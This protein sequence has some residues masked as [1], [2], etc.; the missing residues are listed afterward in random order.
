[1]QWRSVVAR[2]CP[3]AWAS[4]SAPRRKRPAPPTAPALPGSIGC[5]KSSSPVRAPAQWSVIVHR[6]SISPKRRH[7][8]T[9]KHLGGFEPVD[10]AEHD[11]EMGDAETHVFLDPRDYGGRRADDTLPHL[12]GHN[13]ESRRALRQALLQTLLRRL[14]HQRPEPALLDL[15][16]IAPDGAAMGL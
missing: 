4:G 14:D 6:L 3:K 10:A 7:H 15:P 12:L 13:T 16:D 2:R 5:R 11:D 9:G 8:F 1:C